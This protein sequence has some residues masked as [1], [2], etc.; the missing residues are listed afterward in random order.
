MLRWL[1]RL[2]IG[3][4]SNGQTPELTEED[5]LAHQ[6]ARLALGRPTVRRYFADVASVVRTGRWRLTSHRTPEEFVHAWVDVKEMAPVLTAALKI[7]EGNGNGNG[8]P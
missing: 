1:Y 8:G 6:L 3:L 4:P 5:L 2:L 7:A